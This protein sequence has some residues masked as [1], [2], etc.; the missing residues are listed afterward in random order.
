MPW[1]HFG[2]SNRIQIIRSQSS[3]SSQPLR[4]LHTFNN[5]LN[6]LHDESRAYSNIIPNAGVNILS[7]L[8]IFDGRDSLQDYIN[9]QMR[10]LLFRAFDFHAEFEE[11]IDGI[12]LDLDSLLEQYT[13]CYR[14]LP[15]SF[16][17]E[18]E[19]D[20]ESIRLCYGD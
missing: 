5:I 1:R 20:L 6:G 18:S 15:V 2:V 10:D 16:G 12:S 4:Y 8:D 17:Y 13:E 11:L 14:T 7:S 19:A 3:I 9:R